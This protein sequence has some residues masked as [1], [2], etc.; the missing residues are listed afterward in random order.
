MPTTDLTPATT[1][2]LLVVGAG[3]AG[4]AAALFAASRGHD[5]VLIGGP[6]ESIFASGL[7]DLMGVHPPIEKRQWDDPWAAIAAATRDD[8]RHPYAHL[9]A[10]DIRRALDELFA[11]LAEAGLPY[12][13]R[14][15]RN[16]EV[17]TAVGTFKRTYGVPATM[18]SGVEARER[19]DPGLIVDIRGLKGFS[20]CQVA[21]TAAARWPGLSPVRVT[22]PGTE[23]RGEIYGEH[24]ARSLAL[25]EVRKELAERI[26]PHLGSAAVVGM[27]ALLGIGRA[28]E[29][30]DDLARRIGAP[31]FEIPTIPPSV[32]GVRLKETFEQN[33]AARGVRLMLSRRVLSAAP[34]AGGGFEAAVGRES[35]ESVIRSEAVLLATG[36]Y[37]GGGLRAQRG[38][39]RETVFDL[40]VF[41]P[42]GR[43]NWHR[44]D[45]LDPA[46]HPVNRAGLEIDSRFR[47]LGRDRRPAAGGLFAAGALL[48]HQDWMR[49][50]CGAGLAAATAYG[51]VKAFTETAG[52]TADGPQPSPAETGKP[53]G[54][55]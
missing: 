29:I 15:G 44:R 42:E 38:G 46:G 49:M 33:L 4:M 19:R 22:F 18:W 2:R 10:D 39:I 51:A 26:R 52:K 5:T 6:G 48:A 12:R 1:C 54:A 28:H 47:P 53:S 7:I 31:V 37:L 55:P 27:P 11:F 35:V 3:M 16:V 14:S 30:V 23:N 20:A 9:S 25:A 13:L 8:P 32:P 40:P 41:Q 34:L 50:K 21:D 17:L 24:L 43:G 36:R 45:F